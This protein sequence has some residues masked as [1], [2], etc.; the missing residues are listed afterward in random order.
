M[1][2]WLSKKINDVK[3]IYIFKLF[4]KKYMNFK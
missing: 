1:M 2:F 4:L 3:N